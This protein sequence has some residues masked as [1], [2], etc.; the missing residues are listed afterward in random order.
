MKTLADQKRRYIIQDATYIQNSYGYIVESIT[1]LESTQLTLN[2][3]I[4][5]LE[6]VYAK[7][8]NVSC[9]FGTIIFKKFN[10]NLKRNPDLNN[11]KLINNV[12]NGIHQDIPNSFPVKEY[13][14]RD[15]KTCILTSCDVERTFSRYKNIYRDNRTSF[16]LENLKKHVIINCNDKLN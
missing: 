13:N 8:G 4:N 3:S 1:K 6:D 12:L 2:D 14:F 5:I 15:Y 16:T 11:L 10:D 9:A 7:I